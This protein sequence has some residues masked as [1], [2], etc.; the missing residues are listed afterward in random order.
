[1]KTRSSS[2][3]RL[4]GVYLCGKIFWCRYSLDGRQ[5]RISL[6]TGDE[7]AAIAR[8]MEIRANPELTDINRL[9]L[10]C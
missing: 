2:P 4:P 3:Q 9:T 5:H 7:S 8:A 10:D 6:E 1:V